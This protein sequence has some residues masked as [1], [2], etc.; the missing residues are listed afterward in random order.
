M[1]L[2]KYHFV[3]C[4]R[5]RRRVL[6]GAVETRLREIV[7]HTCSEM[8]IQIVAIDVKPDYIYLF[9]NCPPSI[10]PADIMAKIKGVSS[11]LLREEFVNLSHQVSLW[12]RNYLVSTEESISRETIIEYINTQKKRG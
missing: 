9:L 10:S 2:I 3:F 8:D 4:P 1:S 12:T 6:E 7:H 11:K 5:Y